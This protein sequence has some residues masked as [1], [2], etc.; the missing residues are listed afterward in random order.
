M[1]AQAYYL[2]LFLTSKLLSYYIIL[3]RVRTSGHKERIRIRIG[4]EYDNKRN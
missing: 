3:Q 2:R 1:Y 4:A